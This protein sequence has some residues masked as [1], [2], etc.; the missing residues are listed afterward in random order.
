[1]TVEETTPL[2]PWG[3]T[4]LVEFD[5]NRIA[6]VRFT[7]PKKRNAMN[8]TLNREMHA[9]LE[10]LESDDR[11]AVLVLT[12]TEES[13]VRRDGPE[14]VLPRNRRQAPF[15]TEQGPFRRDRTGTTANCS[16]IRS[17]RSP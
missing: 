12:G 3:N 5:E 2:E 13:L 7:P 14:G 1:M 17:R 9:T 8:P 10:Y 16:A 15:N 6:W 11:C 4:V